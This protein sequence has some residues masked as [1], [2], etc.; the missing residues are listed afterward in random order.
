MKAI[1]KMSPRMLAGQIKAQ[2]KKGAKGEY[3]EALKAEAQRRG[4]NLRKKKVK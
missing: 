1:E 3:Y 2:E 4:D